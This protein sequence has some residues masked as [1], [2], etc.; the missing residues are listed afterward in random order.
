MP[1]IVQSKRKVFLTPLII[2]FSFLLP[3]LFLVL[4]V[5]I[6]RASNK[7]NQALIIEE[8]K[9]KVKDVVITVIVILAILF[10]VDAIRIHF[11]N[12]AVEQIKS[13]AVEQ[14]YNQDN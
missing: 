4:G 5:V 12:Q 10:V 1:K 9:T 13:Q 2:L 6:F 3:L 8:E 7:F 14:E 11:R